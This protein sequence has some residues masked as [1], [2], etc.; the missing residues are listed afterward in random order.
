MSE[1]AESNEVHEEVA[2]EEIAVVETE[3][4]TE[5]VANDT[6]ETEDQQLKRKR[7]D[8]DEASADA[9]RATTQPDAAP[10]V[11]VGAPAANASLSVAGDSETLSIAPDKVGQIIGTKVN[12]F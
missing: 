12:Y 11:T 6:N 3:A 2:V 8:D 5:V 1:V 10:A 4:E 7:E 9:K